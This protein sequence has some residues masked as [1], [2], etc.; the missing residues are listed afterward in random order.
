MVSSTRRKAMLAIWTGAARLQSFRVK[1]NKHCY[2]TPQMTFLI[3]RLQFMTSKTIGNIV[4]LSYLSFLGFIPGK[5][6][7]CKFQVACCSFKW[8][9]DASTQWRLWQESVNN[10]FSWRESFNGGAFLAHHGST[11][12]QIYRRLQNIGYIFHWKIE[13]QEIVARCLEAAASKTS[14]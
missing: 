9:T 4:V 8:K 3:D 13:V 12:E 11:W 1:L 5:G 10:S 7:C 2:N 6:L 14:Y